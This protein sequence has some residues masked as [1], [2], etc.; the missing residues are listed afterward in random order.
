MSSRLR[1]LRDENGGSLTET[2]L[3]LMFLAPILVCGTFELASLVFAGIETYNAAHA[4]VSFAA[5]FYEN[6]AYSSDT[7][8]LPTQA[9]VQDAVNREVDDVSNSGL[10]SSTSPSATIYTGCNNNSGVSSGPTSGNTVPT[11]GT[12]YL[13]YVEVTVTN[14]ITPSLHFYGLPSSYT[15]SQTALINLVN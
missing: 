2:A 7:G 5:E 14:T 12:G 3:I 15:V 1:F 10:F 13:P 11:C 6:T 8:T 4:G 9:Q